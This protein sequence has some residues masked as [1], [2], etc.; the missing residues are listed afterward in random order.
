MRILQNARMYGLSMWGTRL[1]S[2]SSSKYL[3]SQ[4]NHCVYQSA[5][6]EYMGL[7]STYRRGDSWSRGFSDDRPCQAV[8][9]R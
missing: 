5:K 6:E 3:T 7:N 4:D 8:R 1:R 9:G 2:R